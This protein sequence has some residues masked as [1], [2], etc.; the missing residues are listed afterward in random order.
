MTTD[1]GASRSVRLL[2]AGGTIAM[3]GSP[4]RPS[5]A[6]IEELQRQAGGRVEAEEFL[7][8]PSVHFSPAQAL[9]LCR[10][11][12]AIARAGTPVVVTHGTDL[13]EEV[14]FL[15][16]LID[17]AEAPIVFTGAMR[18]ASAPG[19]D[20]PANLQAAISVAAG[21]A[22]RGLGV[23]VA[24]AGAVHA[25]RFVR[26]TDS[27]SADAFTSPQSG[28]LGH[29]EEGRVTIR[30]RPP[31][32]PPLTV[33]SLDASVEI[34]TAALG[35]PPE[36]ADAVSDVCDGLVVS[37]PGAGHTPPPFL[38][39]IAAIARTKPVVAVPRPW[40]GAILHETY[41]F[42]GA[43]GDLRARVTACAG[44]LSA[45]AARIAL[46]ACLSAG[47]TEREIKALFARY[48]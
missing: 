24:F 33:G 48:D 14:A 28:P 21:E 18:A 40:R 30:V 39:A 3:S 45:P 37:V 27:T 4:A 12:V 29:V 36:L 5:P 41:G 13:L 2:I 1:R 38:R 31:R 17:D 35:T 9:S 25:A 47:M 16:D 8:A 22:V 26:K 11:A 19:A 46:M 10:R 23:V 34:L 7:V 42:E 15:C 32:H 20:G 44:S 43:E 6:V